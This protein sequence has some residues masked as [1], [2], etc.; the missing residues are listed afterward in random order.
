MVVAVLFTAGTALRQRCI[1][2]ETQ[3]RSKHTGLNPSSPP[4][5]DD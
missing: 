3:L 5:I 1:P 4:L 2:V